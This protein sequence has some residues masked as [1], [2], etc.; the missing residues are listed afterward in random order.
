MFGVQF[1]VF[2]S[3]CVCVCV[4]ASCDCPFLSSYLFLLLCMRACMCTRH[5]VWGHNHLVLV[6]THITGCLCL[7]FAQGEGGLR[8]G[9]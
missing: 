5:K 3:L 4:N 7:R 1:R 6:E 9:L 2:S 8:E